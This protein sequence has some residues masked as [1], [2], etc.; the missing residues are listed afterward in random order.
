MT[1]EAVLRGAPIDQLLIRSPNRFAFRSRV[2]THF[3]LARR[4]R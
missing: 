2:G 4:A 3:P 1:F